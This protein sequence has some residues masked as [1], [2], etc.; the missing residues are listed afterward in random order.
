MNIKNDTGTIVSVNCEHCLKTYKWSTSSSYGIYRKH[1]ERVPPYQAVL[2]KTQTQ[3][4]RY[5][6]NNPPQLFYFSDVKNR[7]KLA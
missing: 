3:I 7:D 4:S 6:T 2:I 1:L 5:D